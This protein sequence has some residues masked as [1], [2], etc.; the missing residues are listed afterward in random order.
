M[1]NKRWALNAAELLWQPF[2]FRVQSCQS[3]SKPLKGRHVDYWTVSEAPSGSNPSW[4]TS[5]EE[6]STIPGISDPQ[7][8]VCLH[9]GSAESIEKV[10][11]GNFTWNFLLR[12]SDYRLQQHVFTRSDEHKDFSHSK[13]YWLQ[14]DLQQQQ[15]DVQGYD[16]DGS[17]VV[18]PVA[19]S[20]PAPACFLIWNCILYPVNSMNT[21]PNQRVCQNIMFARAAVALRPST[22]L[23]PPWSR[24]RSLVEGGGG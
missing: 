10:G 4:P 16:D 9:N 5:L 17:A 12:L 11:E 8:K 22:W 19:H 15:N 3:A 2:Q 23:P 24:A 1:C 21:L 18:P 20:A 13:F 6:S 14:M 7:N